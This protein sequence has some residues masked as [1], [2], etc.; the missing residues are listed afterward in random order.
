MY[1]YVC[2]GNELNLNST[3]LNPYPGIQMNQSTREYRSARVE[4]GPLPH[5]EVYVRKACPSVIYITTHSTI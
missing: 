1:L 2:V 4:S 5:D 3:I